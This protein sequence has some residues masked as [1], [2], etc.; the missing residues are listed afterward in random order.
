MLIGVDK[1]FRCCE[2]RFESGVFS[3]GE[4]VIGEEEEGGGV[5]VF[6]VVGVL[7]GWVVEDRRSEGWGGG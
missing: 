6:G 3:S 1:Y 2:K 4:G 7:V 5:V